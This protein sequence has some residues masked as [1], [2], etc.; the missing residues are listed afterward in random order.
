MSAT[1]QDARFD[2]A[3]SVSHF[4]VGNVGQ[5][6]GR[7]KGSGFNSCNHYL[8]RPK[9]D[10]KKNKWSSINSSDCLDLSAKI[11]YFN[12]LLCLAAYA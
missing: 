12:L 5:Q 10:L 6:G 1:F 2:A 4:I 3:G 11:V 9:G 7:P 8:T